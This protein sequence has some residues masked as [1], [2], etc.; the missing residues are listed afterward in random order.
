M[1]QDGLV[2]FLQNLEESSNFVA[3]FHFRNNEASLD[4][5]VLAR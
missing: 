2:S 4:L 1:F 5:G 3:D